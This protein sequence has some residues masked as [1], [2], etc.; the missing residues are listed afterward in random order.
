MAVK[1]KR[2]CE[3]FDVSEIECPADVNIHGIV[4]QLSPVKVSRKN[5][6]VKYFD[7]RVSD[8]ENI[9]H[10]VYLSHFTP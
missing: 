7:G 10:L 5:D 1:R 3:D 9:M 8:G 2:D 6:K 4:M